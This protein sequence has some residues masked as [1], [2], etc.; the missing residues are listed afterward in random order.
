MIAAAQGKR[1]DEN[2]F[3]ETMN[4]HFEWLAGWEMMKREQVTKP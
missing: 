2:P 4:A 3:P 1:Y